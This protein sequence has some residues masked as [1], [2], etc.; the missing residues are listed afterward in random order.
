METEQSYRMRN[1]F[2]FNFLSTPR[3]K[4]FLQ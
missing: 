1:R 2:R 3:Y 4:K